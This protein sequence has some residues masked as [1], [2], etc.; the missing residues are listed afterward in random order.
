[1]IDNQFFTC[2]T[3]CP[4][5]YFLFFFSFAGRGYSYFLWSWVLGPKQ[6]VLQNVVLRKYDLLQ[7]GV[8]L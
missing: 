6:Q 8:V 7:D 5:I 3:T 2:L 4:Y 1:M